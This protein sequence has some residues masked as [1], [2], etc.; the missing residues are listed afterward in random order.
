MTTI[1]IMRHANA[2]LILLG[3]SPTVS[4]VDVLIDTS[5]LGPAYA[6]PTQVRE[7]CLYYCC[8][9]LFHGVDTFVQM[10][11]RTPIYIYTV[12]V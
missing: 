4:E 12:S 6:V 1:D 2:T 11:F 9:T 10:Y 3:E 7:K 5:Y 8:I